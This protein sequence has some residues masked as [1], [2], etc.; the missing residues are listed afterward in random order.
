[1]RKHY[2]DA[3]ALMQRYGKPD[4]FL[5]VTCNPNWPKIH[6]ALGNNGEVQNRPDLIT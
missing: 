1:M 5:N 2:K 4:I 3:M 6:N